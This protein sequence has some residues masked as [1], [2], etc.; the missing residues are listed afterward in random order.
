M[1][2]ACLPTPLHPLWRLSEH[3]S[4]PE[5]W[6]KRDDL[7][8]NGGGGNKTRKLEFFV[9]DAIEERADTLVTVGAI[10]SNHVRQTAAAAV[11]A[12]MSSVLLL[13][14]F[15]PR[16]DDF[17]ERAGNVL[18]SRLLGAE[19]H[20]DRTPSHIGDEAG[21]EALLDE[22]TR[23]GRTPYRI[24]LGASDHRIGGLGYV[25]CALELVDQ[26]EQLGITFDAIVHCTGSGS[27]MAG[28]LA[29]FHA[30]GV[31]LDVIGI[32]D[33]G[34]AEEG[35]ELVHRLANTTLRELGV[36][37]PL[38]RSRVEVW[39][40][41]AAGGYGIPGDDTYAAIRLAA[42]SEGLF[43]DPVYE[44][45]SMAGMIELVRNGRLARGSRVLYLHMGGAPALHAYAAD[46]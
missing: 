10:Q 19:I 4:G 46:L 28:L 20:V 35:A 17:Y 43:V 34:D 7:T 9:G 25:K 3:L 27:T 42:E 32:H 40:D 21:V 22:L 14:G 30:L 23:Q 26:W 13:R 44:G 16:S 37:E 38:P 8:G 1:P 31:D 2:L 15:V 5:I 29:G 39:G 6:C 45:K 12:G 11:R 18:L 41:F 24:P 33:D 36:D